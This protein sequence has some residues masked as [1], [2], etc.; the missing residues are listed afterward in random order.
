MILFVMLSVSALFAL[1]SS[2]YGLSKHSAVF[3]SICSITSVSVLNG[4]RDLSIGTDLGV[5]GNNVFM[6]ARS[7]ILSF[8]DYMIECRTI[9]MTEYGYAM[10]NYIVAQFTSNVHIFYFVLGIFVN[11]LFYISNF[12]NRGYIPFPIAWVTYLMIIYPATLNLLR[13]GVALALVSLMGSFLLSKKYI[14]AFICILIAFTFHN[15][16]AFALIIYIFLYVMYHLCNTRRQNMAV[17]AFLCISAFVPTIVS[18]LDSKGLL[19][20]KYS[21]YVADATLADSMLNSVIVRI[22]FVILSVYFLIKERK[23]SNKLDKSLF[24]LVGAEILLLPL[25][26]IS[27]SAFRIALY[28]GIYKIPG[29]SLLCKRFGEMRKIA[30]PIYI[31]YLIIYFYIQTVKNGSGEIYPFIVASDIL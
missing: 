26:Q 25:Q 22:P 1:I 14:S 21:Q 24:G 6:Q 13:Q 10:F 19:S 28:Y 11:G 3:F 7:N 16:S 17:F 23:E 5:Y 30:Y 15:S 31:I 9:G 29:Y 12:R 20:D 27:S 4:I 8:H 18:V 2:S